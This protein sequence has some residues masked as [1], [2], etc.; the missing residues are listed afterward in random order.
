MGFFSFLSIMFVS[1][2]HGQ[3]F[4][5]NLKLLIRASIFNT[6]EDFYEEETLWIQALQILD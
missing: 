3:Y 2:I 1:L 4:F 5:R 6:E